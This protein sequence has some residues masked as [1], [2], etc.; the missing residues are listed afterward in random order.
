MDVDNAIDMQTWAVDY[1]YLKTMG[2]EIVKGR[3]FSPEFGTDST[4][5]LITETTAK[6]LGYDDPIN[7]NL[8]APAGEYEDNSFVPLHIIGVVKDFHFESLR[9]EIG[10]LCMRLG[11]STGTISFKVAAA[12]TGGLINQI[13]NKWKAMAPELPFSYR[14]LDDSFN[15]MYKNEQRVGS[16]AITFAVLA[17]LIACLGLFGLVTYMAEQRT[18]EIGIRKVL[19]ASITNVV[20]MISKDFLVL[21]AVACVIAFPVA[22]YAMDKWLA[23][24]AYRIDIEWWIF[25]AAGF[26]ALAIALITISFKA[27]KAAIVNPVKSLRTE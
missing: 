13:E 1:D 17:I 8:Y 26:T 6:L 3:N 11:N 18:K 22:W 24:Y 9:Q 7:K 20:T 25:L 15:E 21:V 16:L 4:A 19:G 10:P 23:D 27:I 5:I 2:M 12:S 14:F